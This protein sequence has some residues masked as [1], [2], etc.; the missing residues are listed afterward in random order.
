MITT[1]DWL[2]SRLDGPRTLEVEVLARV[3]YRLVQIDFHRYPARYLVP[4]DGVFTLGNRLQ[5][6]GFQALSTYLAACA[7]HL[8]PRAGSA[9]HWRNTVIRRSRTRALNTFL[10]KPWKPVP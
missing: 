3:A 6:E 8:T 1:D 5:V 9:L 7:Y 10:G 4:S 2:T